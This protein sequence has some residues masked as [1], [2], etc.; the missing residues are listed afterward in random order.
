MHLSPR[1][2]SCLA[3]DLGR[4]VVCSPSDRGWLQILTVFAFALV[5]ACSSP[6]NHPLPPC[7]SEV[8]P[9]IPLSEKARGSSENLSLN[10][11]KGFL[12]IFLS[13]FILQMKKH[14][15]SWSYTLGSFLTDLSLTILLWPFQEN[16]DVRNSN[17][18]S[19]G[20]SS[21]WARCNKLLGKVLIAV[22]FIWS[23]TMI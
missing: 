7:L 14:S 1:E 20:S 18:Y 4:E 11:P 6:I 5:R 19:Q 23:V 9:L 22:T 2:T 21:N 13:C 17:D 16:Q 3:A 10:T 12:G 8:K 15:N